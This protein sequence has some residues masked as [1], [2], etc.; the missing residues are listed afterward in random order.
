M[1]GRI[2]LGN[3]LKLENW[4]K[5]NHLVPLTMTPGPNKSESFLPSFWNHRPLGH[6]GFVITL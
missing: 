2:L 3:T 5:K 4:K 1:L 6:V